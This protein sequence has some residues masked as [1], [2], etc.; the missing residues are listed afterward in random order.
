MKRRGRAQSRVSSAIY[1]RPFGSRRLALLR[2]GSAQSA[3]AE[4]ARAELKKRR[5]KLVKQGSDL[6]KID[7][8]GRHKVRI[9]TKK[10]RYMAAFFEG[11]PGVAAN[12]KP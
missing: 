5:K 1:G 4:F 11:V 9:T 12:L 7:R 3:V 2:G 10:F 6:D 8:L